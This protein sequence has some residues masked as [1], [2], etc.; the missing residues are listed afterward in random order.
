MGCFPDLLEYHFGWAASRADT[1]TWIWVKGLY[2]E[3]ASGKSWQGE[4]GSKTGKERKPNEHILRHLDLP[5]HLVFW[6]A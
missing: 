1:G 5:V 3:S 6:E 4:E 2:E